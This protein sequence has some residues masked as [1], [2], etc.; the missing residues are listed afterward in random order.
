MEEVR[1]TKYN[2]LIVNDILRTQNKI[3]NTELK[4]IGEKFVICA[5]ALAITHGALMSDD[6]S[7]TAGIFVGAASIAALVYTKNKIKNLKAE[8]K[9]LIKKVV[10][11]IMSKK[12]ENSLSLFLFLN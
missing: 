5:G 1:F 10:E 9:T 6:I 3:E 12:G 11:I 4:T 8:E 2:E 7:F